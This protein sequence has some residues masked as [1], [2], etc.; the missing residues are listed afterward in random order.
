MKYLSVPALYLEI[1]LFS[2]AIMLLVVVKSTGIMKIV[3]QGR[4][5]CACITTIVFILSDM[6]VYMRYAVH[7]AA[8]LIIALKSVYFLSTT[9]MCYQWMRFFASYDQP[10]REISPKKEAYILIPA[11]IQ[12]AATILNVNMGFMFYV[13]DSGVFR[14]GKLFLIQY[15]FAYI[16]V[17]AAAANAV[18]KMVRNKNYVDKD[19]FINTLIFLFLPAAAGIFQYFVQGLPAACVAVTFCVLSMYFNAISD[20]ISVDPLTKLNNRKELMRSISRRMKNFRDDGP[21]LYLFILDA[22]LF[23]GINDTYGHLEGDKALKR[24]AEAMREACQPLKRRATIARYGGDEF[25]I[26][27]EFEGDETPESLCIEINRILSCLNK[28]DNSPYELTV[29]IGVAK[30]TPF[31]STV[32]QFMSIADEELY[33]VKKARKIKR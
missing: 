1:N 6:V 2:V 21:A 25:V 8:G 13:D 9:L 28:V 27:A 16:Y 11:M 15:A 20:I 30:Y 5:I 19:R 26:A 31:I 18:A 3:Q 22:N 17:A 23:K 29:S 7:F 24:I 33:K 14:S 10:E 12:V 4:F 32:R